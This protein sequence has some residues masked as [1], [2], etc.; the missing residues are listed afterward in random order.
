[1]TM[2]SNRPT[3]LHPLTWTEVQ[4]AAMDVA[5]RHAGD[6][7]P[8]GVWGVPRGG[9]TPAAMVASYLR[10]PLADGPGPGVLVVDDL[11]D[12]GRTLERYASTGPVDA[13][14]RKPGAPAHLAPCAVP[15]EGWVVFPWEAEAEQ[16]GPADAV[17]RILQHVGEDPEREGLRDTP[18]RVLRAFTEMTAGYGE[19]PAAILSTVFDEQH[20]QM[21]VLSGI[22]FTALCEHHL[23]PFVG[24]ATVGYVPNGKVVGLSKLARLVECFARRL[25][26]QERMTNQVAQAVMEHLQPLGVGVIIEA[27]HSCMGCR[28]VRKPSAVMKTSALAGIMRWDSTARG[29]FL[30]LAT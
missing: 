3:D 12:S 13:L 21:V 18:G 6:P 27:H 16:H 4:N 2:T 25:Q 1:M 19:D 9:I 5:G 11:V 26:V 17:V 23:L 22:E 29:E 20:D 8:A 30:R 14:Y 10:V 24:T 28:G 15:V 7:M